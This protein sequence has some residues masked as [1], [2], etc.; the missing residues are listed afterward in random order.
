VDADPHNHA[1]WSGAFVFIARLISTSQMDL[2]AILS[3]VLN[4]TQLVAPLALPSAITGFVA[5]ELAQGRRQNG[6]LFFTSRT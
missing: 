4:L 6:E 1:D 5:E 3:L 2:L